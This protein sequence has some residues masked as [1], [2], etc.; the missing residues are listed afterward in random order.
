MDVY[1]CFLNKA[2]STVL[3]ANN[4]LDVSGQTDW[5]GNY[6][7]STLNEYRRKIKIFQQRLRRRQR[8][9]TNMKGMLLMLNEN[10]QGNES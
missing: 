1:D 10:G 8:R 4:T 2:P 3:T 6:L 7:Q 5:T 9:M